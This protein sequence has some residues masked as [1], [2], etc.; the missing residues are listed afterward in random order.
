MQVPNPTHRVWRDFKNV[1]LH[2]PC[3]ILFPPGAGGNFILTQIGASAL[4]HCDD[5]NEYISDNTYWFGMERGNWFHMDGVH[6]DQDCDLL[7][8]MAADMALRIGNLRKKLFAACH[9]PPTITA[10]VIDYSTDELIIIN[11]QPED[12]WIL[13]ALHW[14]KTYFGTA[15]DDKLHVTAEIISHNRYCGR[16]NLSEFQMLT[17]S[18]GAQ[19]G[20][21]LMAT[22][23]SWHYFLDSKA[24]G[25][26]DPYD[27]AGFAEYLANHWNRYRRGW[28]NRDNLPAGIQ[29]Q[30]RVDYCKHLARAV[31][32]IDYRQLFF[33]LLL[34][35]HGALSLVDKQAVLRYSE[36][37]LKVLTTVSKFLAV[38]HGSM[39]HQG[40]A[41]LQQDLKST[42]LLA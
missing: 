3:T 25:V 15:L 24:D 34:P 13:H 31:T 4:E 14:Y 27:I 20:I 33:K 16:I 37:N 26:D 21:N 38:Q 18:L 12:L 23:I 11:V 17:R 2:I 40:I 9:Q 22:P 36:N 7:Y 29:Y 6:D 5:T 35:D 42:G 1:Q 30:K 39:L 8:D 32:E 41:G 28:S 19:L 10:H